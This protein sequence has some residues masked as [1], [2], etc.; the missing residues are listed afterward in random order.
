MSCVFSDYLNQQIVSQMIAS[1]G[2]LYNLSMGLFVNNVAI[3]EDTVFSNLTEASFDG[4]VRHTAVTF[5]TAYVDSSGGW[6]VQT[7]L[8][9]FL[10]TDSAE[11]QTVY[12]YF[13]I[14][15]TS[16]GASE[17]LVAETF[18]SPVSLA[19]AN[20]S[21]FISGQVMLGGNSGTNGTATVI[22]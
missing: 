4:Y 17:L 3:T 10:M 16:S 8:Y 20:N 14:N 15:P 12:G 7:G 22:S 2:P 13:L 9:Q 6:A 11:P 1:G 21:I 5:D 18:A 19:Q